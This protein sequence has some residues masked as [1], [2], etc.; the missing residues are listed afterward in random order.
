MEYGMWN[1]MEYGME[2]GI[3]SL[4]TNYAR[5]RDALTKAM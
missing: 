3:L 2:Y 5:M 4:S 1:G